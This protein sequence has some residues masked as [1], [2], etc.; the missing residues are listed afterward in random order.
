[1]ANVTLDEG[2][3]TDLSLSSFPATP[4]SSKTGWRRRDRPIVELNL[5]NAMG[6]LNKYC[7]RLPCDTFTQLSVLKK[8]DQLPDG[9]FQTSLV[10]PNNSHLRGIIQGDPQDTEALSKQAAALEACLRLREA[11]E[12]DDFLFHHGKEIEKYRIETDP[13]PP[14]ND[15]QKQKN[16]V[17]Q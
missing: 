14:S 7:N 10:L 2:Y 16:K 17:R 9:S 5:E 15:Y 13:F 8:T 11:G 1:M 3:G 4:E 6:L 12:L